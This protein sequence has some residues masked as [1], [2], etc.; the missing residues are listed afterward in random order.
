[1]LHIYFSFIYFSCAVVNCCLS[2][3]V[4]ALV[5]FVSFLC[6]I[7]ASAFYKYSINRE[8]IL[9]SDTTTLLTMKSSISSPLPY[10]RTTNSI[11][12]S[13]TSSLSEVDILMDQNTND[14]EENDESIF[15]N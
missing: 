7:L 10:V 11:D 3:G 12:I 8:R 14:N 6:A 2:S 15:D 9:L 13:R 4:S 1:M 5:T